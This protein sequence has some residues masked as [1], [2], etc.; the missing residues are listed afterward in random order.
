MPTPPR[1]RGPRWPIRCAP[2]R[3]GGPVQARVAGSEAVWQEP[4]LPDFAPA[5]GGGSLAPHRRMPAHVRFVRSRRRG[6]A[7]HGPGA[8]AGC[9]RARADPGLRHP[10]PGCPRGELA[11]A[12]PGLFEPQGDH[13]LGERAGDPRCRGAVR[14]G[15]DHFR[16]GAGALARAGGPGAG[17]HRRRLPLH[18]RAGRPEGVHRALRPPGALAARR[19]AAGAGPGRQPA[20]SSA[21]RGALPRQALPA[22]GR[23]ALSG[24]GRLGQPQPRRL[25]RPPARDLLRRRRRGRLPPLPRLLRRERAAL[26]PD[27][28]RPAGGE[29]ARGRGAAAR[30]A[31]RPG[32]APGGAVLSLPQGPG[33]HRRDPAPAGGIGPFGGRPA[34]GGRARRRAPADQP[35]SQP[36]WRHRDQRRGL[37]RAPIAPMRR[38]RSRRRPTACPRRGS[39][40]RGAS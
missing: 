14:R 6:A 25:L 8:T 1:P 35:R 18:R 20:L 26:G 38:G 15:R 7:R 22:R 4:V 29:R 12:V 9:S 36:Q 16:L 17:H 40:S 19:A 2:S 34:R 11:G 31:G 5:G 33:R 3:A 37:R 21:A 10:R 39:T 27:P 32:G 24:R 23:G 13:L 30:R 28:G